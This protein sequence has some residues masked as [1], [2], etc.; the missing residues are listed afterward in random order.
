[1]GNRRGWSAGQLTTGLGIGESAA[2]RSNASKQAD[3]CSF[4][5]YSIIIDSTQCE[6]RPSPI[7]GCAAQAFGVLDPSRRKDKCQNLQHMLALAH[8]STRLRALCL[9][10]LWSKLDLSSVRSVARARELHQIATSAALPG[11]TP[12]PLCH[13]NWLAFKW[14]CNP[15]RI[16]NKERMS[17]PETVGTLAQLVFM[18]RSWIPRAN[19]AN[20]QRAA[21]ER[22]IARG[23]LATPWTDHVIPCDDIPEHERV[24]LGSGPDWR[25]PEAIESLE[26]FKDAVIEL[27]IGVAGNGRF[28]FFERSSSIMSIPEEV[29]QA[30]ARC[31]SLRCFSFRYGIP[32]FRNSGSNMRESPVPYTNASLTCG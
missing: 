18:D 20:S 8:T 5:L 4:C 24:E 2:H 11:S 25:G 3:A 12:S 19:N 30:L 17:V 21:I 6:H 1:M 22:R 23:L 10:K 15:K 32:T 14:D 16:L 28:S 27:S 13:V 26:V 9:E 7:G 31:R 29:I